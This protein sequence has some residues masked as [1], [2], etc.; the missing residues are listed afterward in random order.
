MSQEIREAQD[1][2]EIAKNLHYQWSAGEVCFDCPCGVKE[3]IL[4]E[5]G[6]TETCEG[7]GRTYRNV[8]YVEVK[9]A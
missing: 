1:G 6:E 3:I 4:S 8:H 5:S 9:Q 7:C 2:F